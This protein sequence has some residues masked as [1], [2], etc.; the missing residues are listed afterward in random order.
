MN[1]MRLF[2]IWFLVLLLLTGAAVPSQAAVQNSGV[3]IHVKS[4]E[5]AN[6]M[7]FLVVERPTTPQIAARVAIRA[8]SAL[9]AAGKT[10]IAHMLEHM[11]FKGTKNFGTRDFQQ[12]EAL[13][14]RI[15]AAYQMVRAE[16]TRRHPDPTVIRQKLDEMEQLRLDVQKIYVPQ[17][18]SAQLGRNGAVGV[19]AFT[20]KDQTQYMMSI[21]S[22][23]LEQWFSIVSEQLMEP[24]WREFYVEREVVQRE[25]AFRY[26]N[27]PN[28]AAWLDLEAT[29]YQA[30]PYRN[31]VIGWKSDMENFSTEDAISFHRRYY[32]PSNAVCVLVGDLTVEQ[33]R[34][35]AEIY[36]ARYP[37]GS[38]SPEKITEEPPQQGPRSSIRYLKGARTP[39]VRIGFHGPPMGSRDFYAQDAAIMILSQGHSAR[40]TRNLVDKGL[41]VQAWAYNP[42]QRYA[43]MV[44]LGG[45][46]N[47]PDLA[48]NKTED[49]KRRAYLKACEEL[50]DLLLAEVDRLKT[51]T[52]TMRELD[53]I[54]KLNRREFMDRLR[55][56]EELAGTLASLEVQVGWRYLT[57]YLDEFSK[58]TPED[59][60]RVAN[61]YLGADNRTAVYILPGGEP[62][63]P[64]Q[65]YSEIR[66]LG[67]SAAVRTSKS[68]DFTN[69]S[70]YPT[71][72]GWRHP[73]SFDRQPKKISYPAAERFKANRAS[74]FFLPDDE[75]PLIDL[76]IMIK[77]GE[78]DL[79]AGKTGLTDI[80][81]SALIR[82]GTARYTPAEL[83]MALDENAIRLSVSIHDEEAAVNLSVI[84]DDWEK[85]LEILKDVLTAPRFDAD[86]VDVA[87]NQALV[88]LKRAGEDAQAVARRE[89]MLWH[90]S[91]HPY[92]RDP[93]LGLKTIPNLTPQDLK[94]F[95]ADYF[96]PSNMVVAVAGDITREKVGADLEQLFAKLP[97]TTAP[98][99][100][101]APPPEN[102]PMLTLIDKP[103]QIQSQ[104]VLAL[105]GVPRIHPDYWK[106]SM[107]SDI[108]GGSDS[109]LY[110]RLRDDLGLVYAAWFYQSYKWEAGLLT[111][112]I[113]CKS[114]QTRD[115]IV[116]TLKIMQDLQKDI[117]PAV[118]ELKRLD[119]LNSFVFNVDTPFALAK[120]YGRYYLRKEPMDTLDRIQETFIRASRSELIRLAQ[121]YLEPDKIQLVVVADLKTPIDAG[122][123]TLE[124]DLIA[125]AR[126]R[127]L[128]FRKIALR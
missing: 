63:A 57:T 86:V 99:R 92:G 29:A 44:V 107:L 124:A 40:L 125:A 66:S 38:R 90:F 61:T 27:N 60:Q 73:L 2:R 77:A 71:P 127:G 28:G 47:E 34:K 37:A 39:L 54:K 106:L 33:A 112:Y 83:A 18:F 41:A 93:Q 101:L 79:D 48:G 81:N 109:L 5:L 32:N 98:V 85:G 94:K 70:S 115:A 20:S 56:N 103:G 19:N 116:E 26:I 17:A 89:A 113:G 74:V 96:V 105:R 22:D 80:I 24:S 117:P 43:G 78:I 36:F 11:M 51:E 45:S 123:T 42:D 58:V 3:Q 25:W 122:G 10:G 68:T 62:E 88:A 97:Q 31:P 4:F 6:G 50:T 84:R 114:E 75:L 55:S 15:E 111:G 128:P 7:L 104:V 91:G 82:G 102:G 72:A 16:K 120:V 65:S 126:K 110:Q 64:P 14:A 118:F 67:G 100:H 21:P 9:E 95:I 35:L 59:I 108:F 69:H 8:G 13:Q 121:A 49:E 12:D 1:R 76:S 52:V 23:M 119:T 53:R 46:P 30:H 87:K